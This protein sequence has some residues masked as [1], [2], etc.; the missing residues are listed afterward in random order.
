MSQISN[1]NLLF[2]QTP[3]VPIAASIPTQFFSGGT[4]VRQNRME[5][6]KEMQTFG[7]LR[8]NLEEFK[9]AKISFSISSMILLMIYL[10]F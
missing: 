3:L 7:S 2:T 6:H 1:N 9:S 4:D 8:Q 10:F 5:V